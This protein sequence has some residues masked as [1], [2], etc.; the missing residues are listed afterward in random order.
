MDKLQNSTVCNN[1]E[2]EIKLSRLLADMLIKDGKHV[3]KDDGGMN[4]HAMVFV[5]ETRKA[6][7]GKASM[8]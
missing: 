8:E 2:L 5:E 6:Q 1:D 4:I 3:F 7:L